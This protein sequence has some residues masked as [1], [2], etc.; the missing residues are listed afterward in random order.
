MIALTDD[1]LATITRLAYPLA[2]R[3]RGLYLEAV[4]R[5][6]NGVE[7]GDG[8][9]HT[10]AVAAQREILSGPAARAG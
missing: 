2:P 10:A 9:V 3:Q 6:L 1:Q 8:T 7:I 5:R 4:A